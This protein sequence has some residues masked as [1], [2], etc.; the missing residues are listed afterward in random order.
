M[1]A[2]AS[3]GSGLSLRGD[4]VHISTPNRVVVAMARLAVPPVGFAHLVPSSTGVGWDVAPI[5]SGTY[6]R[7]VS[8]GP[9]VEIVTG[10]EQAGAIV[11]TDGAGFTVEGRPTG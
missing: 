4:A 1:A 2:I 5:A 11:S 3:Y 9:G 10:I 8:G 7:F 6:A